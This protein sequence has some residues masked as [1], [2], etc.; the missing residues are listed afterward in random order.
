MYV[1]MYVRT[2]AGVLTTS[3]GLPVIRLVLAGLKCGEVGSSG[4]RNGY[5]SHT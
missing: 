2:Y 1:C 5:P 4:Q 3:R